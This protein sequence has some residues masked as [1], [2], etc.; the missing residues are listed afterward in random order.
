MNG[1]VKVIAVSALGVVLAGCMAKKLSPTELAAL[2]GGTTT[3]IA[4]ER[5]PPVAYLT[6]KKLYNVNYR[7]LVEGKIVAR[8]PHC[9]VARFTLP[10]GQ[11]SLSVG[12]P[13]GTLFATNGLS[14]PMIFRP[15]AKQYL[16]VSA[17]NYSRNVSFVSSERALPVIAQ[18]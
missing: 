17:Q 6:G 7:I 1:L 15:G 3:V 11:R 18:N 4:Y 8:L 10:S 14:R 16:E 2:R 9:G 13:S 5:C 12:D